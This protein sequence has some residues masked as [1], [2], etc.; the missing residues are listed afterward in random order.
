MFILAS[1]SPRRKELLSKIVPSFRIVVPEV[2]ESSLSF[3]SPKDLP[4]EESKLKAY[5]VA[6]RFPDDE[7]LACDTV[8]LLDGVALGKPKDD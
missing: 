7:V 2:D 5:A 6:S 3:L 4:A 1:S 8:V